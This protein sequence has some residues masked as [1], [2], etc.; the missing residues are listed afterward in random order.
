MTF[1]VLEVI[2]KHYSR[3]AV[4]SLHEVVKSTYFRPHFALLLL[5]AYFIYTVLIVLLF[6]VFG[7]LVELYSILFSASFAKQYLFIFFWAKVR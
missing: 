4:A 1:L 6:F 2:M 7:V 3:A 5:P